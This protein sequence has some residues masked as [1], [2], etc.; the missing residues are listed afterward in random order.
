[1]I[2]E[3][4][5]IYCCGPRRL[6]VQ[7]AKRILCGADQKQRCCRGPRR[8]RCVALSPRTLT[9]ISTPGQTTPTRT[10]RNPKKIAC[11]MFCV[12]VSVPLYIPDGL[13]P[14]NFR[15]TQPSTLSGT[16]HEYR[17]KCRDA[18]QLGSK[19][20]H[21]SFHLWIN[22]WVAGKP[23]IS[24]C[25]IR[26]LSIKRCTNIGALFYCRPISG[27][28]SRLQHSINPFDRRHFSVADPKVWSFLPDYIAR[29]PQ[30]VNMGV[31]PS[32]YPSV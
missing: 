20:R 18:L 31:I 6:D 3:R 30:P 11:S 12:A 15:P 1:M 9:D 28:T 14:T 32:L 2:D 26:E 23:R 25:L 13:L 7:R 29:C 4:W 10:Y 17:P 24:E 21:G 16:E 8:C 27:M 22:L 19:G 5:K